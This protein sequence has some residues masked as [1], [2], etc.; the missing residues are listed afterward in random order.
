MPAISN[1][2]SYMSDHLN[3][4]ISKAAKNSINNSEIVC[5]NECVHISLSWGT[6][7][8]LQSTDDLEQVPDNNH[9]IFCDILWVD[10]SESI[11]TAT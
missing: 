9:T 7:R 11:P 2:I 5:G 8:N 6:L 1:S 10:I 3:T 4:K